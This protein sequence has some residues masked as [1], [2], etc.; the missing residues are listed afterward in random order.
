MCVAHVIKHNL[1]TMLLWYLHCIQELSQMN[2]VGFPEKPPELDLNRLEE[3]FI[4]P[5]STFMTIQSL[6]VCGLVSAGQKLLIG[7]V[8]HVAN[9]VGTTVSTLPHM[10]DDIDTVAFRIKRKKHI[11]QLYLQKMYV[12]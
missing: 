11:K 1:Q 6:P 9:D 7:N 10:L 5:L 3:F 12:L 4:A 8:V 2:K